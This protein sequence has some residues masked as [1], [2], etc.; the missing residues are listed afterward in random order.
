MNPIIIAK[1]PRIMD[2]VDGSLL[3]SFLILKPINKDEIPKTSKLNP[4]IIEISSAENIGNIMNIKPIIIE[5]NPAL[6]LNSIYGHLQFNELIFIY[7]W[8][9]IYYCGLI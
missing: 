7:L 5:I 1:I 8:D 6:L 2:N 9:I 4:T 3:M